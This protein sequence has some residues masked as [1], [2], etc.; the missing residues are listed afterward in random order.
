MGNQL[1]E[2]PGNGLVLPPLLKLRPTNTSKNYSVR[3]TCPVR[4]DDLAAWGGV[5]RDISLFRY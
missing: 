4:G 1:A 3:K 5:S 2:L